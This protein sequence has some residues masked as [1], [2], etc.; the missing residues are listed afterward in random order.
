MKKTLTILNMLVAVLWA[1][2][3]TSSNSST[4]VG[5]NAG[6][7]SQY[8]E[9]T[10]STNSYPAGEQPGVVQGDPPIT[11]ME[12][13]ME[14]GEVYPGEDYYVYAIVDNPD[15]R[16]VQYEWSIASG[17]VTDV[18]EA[19]RGRLVTL[20]EQEYADALKTAT[21]AATEP[22][23][24]GEPAT[25]PT[26]AGGTPT[27]PAD[28]TAPGTP[29]GTPPAGT[30]PGAALPSGARNPV[31]QGPVAPV[32]TDQT[33]KPDTSGQGN[34]LTSGGTPDRQQAEVT[35]DKGGGNDS[36]L[37]LYN[38]LK[39]R[40]RVG[41]IS[42][43]DKMKLRELEEKYGTPISFAPSV[44]FLERRIVSGPGEE[45]VTVT[46]STNQTES[47]TSE[48]ADAGDLEST[49]G[50]NAGS[51]SVLAIDA[52]SA[53]LAARTAL[54]KLDREQASQPGNVADE[55]SPRLRDGELIE[56]TNHPASE[57]QAGSLRGDYRT[58]QDQGELS[59]RRPLGSAVS[60]E[61]SAPLTADESF[62]A[63]TFT[64]DEPFIMWTPSVPGEV[65]IYVKV[66]YKE[67]LLSEV[68]A[69]PVTVSLREPTLTISD[70]FPD[71]VKEDDAFL[72][73]IDGD[74]IPAFDKGLITLTY[75][76]NALSFREAELG[77]IFDDAPDAKLF[78]AQPDKNNGRV[79]LA[80]DSNT[81][82]ADLGGTDPVIYIRF[83]AKKDLEDESSTGLALVT[84]STATYILD[85]D[86]NNVLPIPVEKPAYRTEIT[87]PPANANYPRDENALSPEGP[88]VAGEQPPAGGV[89]G[90]KPLPTPT[91]PITGGQPGAND[92][93]P[94]DTGRGNEGLKGGSSA[95]EPPV[96][97]PPVDKETPPAESGGESTGGSDQ[98]QNVGPMPPTPKGEVGPVKK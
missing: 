59:R 5:S 6:Y 43:E 82:I 86:G 26:A 83:K 22:A 13:G 60:D 67:E 24:A 53:V 29:P 66:T 14:T 74:N 56:D 4:S 41:F 51:S 81:E 21:P 16:E 32:V 95:T 72:V 11:L 33:G 77:E 55:Y 31:N 92:V 88:A 61:E 12:V 76:I 44:P 34:Q 54:E 57:D 69:L 64:T 18:P 17:D 2:A 73:R 19:E 39:E 80:L 48:P 3:C 71:I 96:V 20:V 37:A 91:A 79:L 98:N 62:E 87:L 38:D 68:R 85:H 30:P 84:D 23:P 49:A 28:T 52:S 78:Y 27:K 8:R 90:G 25:D 35:T 93:K 1:V 70:E 40:A 58:W 89:T 94:V 7:D 36:E 47:N 10:R 75:D 65:S 50:A 45:E 15:N 46:S 63:Y 42:H 9:Q 97:A